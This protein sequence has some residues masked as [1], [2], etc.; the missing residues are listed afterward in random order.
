VAD[1]LSPLDAAP[2]PS[3]IRGGQRLPRAFFAREPQLVA[4]DLLGTVITTGTGDDRVAVRL[5]ET[6]AYH[7]D[8][9]PA[10]HAFRG[11]TERNAVMFGRAGHLYLYF[12]YGMHWC[13]NIVTGSPG[14]ASAVL[15]RA[16]E[17][18]A[19]VELARLRR[20]ANRVGRELASGPARL[21]T[22]LGWGSGDSARA[23]IGADLCG[24]SAEPVGSPA[25]I[26]AGTGTAV[27]IDVA[28]GPRVGVAAA[29][30]APLRFWIAGDP[31]VS[32][33]RPRVFKRRPAAGR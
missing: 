33:Y 26:Y 14:E 8:T 17:V 18:I 10:S 2:A 27:E 28:T 13:A 30:E 32:T 6:E 23:A 9:D 1:P 25:R 12:V 19:G 3:S 16:G 5:T 24:R 4:R 31:T 7:G 21:A 20:P 22:V 15:L 11:P 29:A